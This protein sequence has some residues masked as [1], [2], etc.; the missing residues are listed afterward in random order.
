MHPA[1]PLPRCDCKMCSLSPIQTQLAGSVVQT[2]A[3]ALPVSWH[4]GNGE[5]DFGVLLFCSYWWPG[6]AGWPRS[7]VA[8][9][10][11][12]AS[13]PTARPHTL[14]YHSVHRCVSVP[15]CIP[16]LVTLM[17]CHLFPIAF[18]SFYFLSPCCHFSHTQRL[19][20]GGGEI[21]TENKREWG[22]RGVRERA[23]R[24]RG[25]KTKGEGWGGRRGPWGELFILRHDTW[26]QSTSLW[27]T[28]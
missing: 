2:C 23:E 21:R 13:P 8:R 22:R 4:R 15:P 26:G 28:S 18:H 7:R 16:M 6:S 11:L 20:T 9:D 14:I 1:A 12:K 27:V 10:Q 3:P 19:I 17:S 25:G 24:E 5:I